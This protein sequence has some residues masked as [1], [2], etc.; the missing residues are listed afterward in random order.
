[1]NITEIL[2]ESLRVVFL[3]VVSYLLTDGV[4]NYLVVHFAGE[5]L[6]LELIVLITG[7]L[8]SVL[9]GIEKQLHKNESKFQLPV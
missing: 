5:S 7:L 1:M 6:S 2:K 4:I 3:A 8:T 9:R